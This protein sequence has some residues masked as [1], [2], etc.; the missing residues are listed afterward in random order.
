MEPVPFSNTKQRLPPGFR[1][2]LEVFAKEVIRKKPENV[3]EFG[4]QF[5]EEMLAERER[6]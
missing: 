5:F 2:L 4:A 1:N 6:M 3:V